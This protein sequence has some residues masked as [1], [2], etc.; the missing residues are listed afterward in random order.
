MNRSGRF[1]FFH[2]LL[3]HQL[4][5]PQ[6]QS[7]WKGIRAHENSSLLNEDK[8]NLCSLKLSYAWDVHFVKLSETFKIP[9]VPEHFYNFLLILDDNQQ[10]V[11][12]SRI[13]VSIQVMKMIHYN[14]PLGRDTSQHIFLYSVGKPATGHFFIFVIMHQAYI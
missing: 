13:S 11:I 14:R 8:R 4:S 10:I 12:F 9:A 2:Q 3:T 1:S 5:F 7:S 6:E